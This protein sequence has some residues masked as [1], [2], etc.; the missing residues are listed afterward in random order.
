MTTDNKTFYEVLGVPRNAKA[1]EIERGY[2]RLRASMQ[3]ESS[4]PDPRRAAMAKVAYDTLCDPGRRAE[5]DD[6]LGFDASAARPDRPGR[7]IGPA[8]ALLALMAIA[9]GGYYYFVMRPSAGPAV[10]GQQSFDP[11]QL[12]Q[13]VAPYVGRV[14]GAMVSGQVRDVGLAVATGE[15]E[16][17]TT[18]RGLAPGMVLTVKQEGFTARAELDRVNQDLDVCTLKVRGIAEGAKVRGDVP[19]AREKL[20]AVLLDA[21][22]LQ[23][24]QV[25]IERS[26]PDA[27]G[28]AYA[29]KAAVSLPNG[30]PVFDA[31][32]RL[33]G[34]VTTPHEFGEGIVAALGAARIAQARGASGPAPTVAAAPAA[35]DSASA[36]SAAAARSASPAP[37]AAPA[38]RGGS[39]GTLV[40]EGFSTLWKEDYRGHMIE[41]MDDVKKGAVG[42]PI[43]YWTLWSGRD[44]E[45]A[46][47]SHCLV[48]FGAEQE[49]VAD[50]DQVPGA[51]PADGYW[52]CA[53]TRFQVEL[54]DLPVG[55]Y[56]FTIFVDGKSVAES[57]IRVEKRFFTPT[58]KAVLVLFVGLG[59]L[60][61]LRRNKVVKL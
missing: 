26:I 45:V 28:H 33:V 32:A 46:H 35:A 29:L 10:A 22:P 12:L 16:M 50:Y 14:Q 5:Y 7:R 42:I 2:S 17:A 25:A 20:Q 23:A 27:H 11:S 19:A 15:N 39:G 40:G 3:R 37:A 53:L 41:A 57:A 4:A 61:F 52:Y 18:C 6:S 34:I 55:E 56:R 49:V 30:T 60:A 54:D 13:A 51:Q 48:T 58:V 1:G 8:L 59:L 44:P 9:G 47:T 36:A 24:R 38:S 43:A 31:Q 21:G